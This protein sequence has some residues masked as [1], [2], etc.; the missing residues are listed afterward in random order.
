[1]SHSYTKPKSHYDV[2]EYKKTPLDGLEQLVLVGSSASKGEEYTCHCGL[3]RDISP[4]HLF[5]RLLEV[6]VWKTAK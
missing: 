6:L 4:Y 2:G 5:Q 3:A 1:M